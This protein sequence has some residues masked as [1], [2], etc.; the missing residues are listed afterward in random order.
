M[1][2]TLCFSAGHK[3]FSHKS[4]DINRISVAWWKHA[5]PQHQRISPQNMD[6]FFFFFILSSKSILLVS[7]LCVSEMVCISREKSEGNEKEKQLEGCKNLTR[8]LSKEITIHL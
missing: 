8:L 4:F 5:A 7:N 6:L 3:M 1:K 2:K